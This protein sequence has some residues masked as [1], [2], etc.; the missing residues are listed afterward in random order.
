MADPTRF[1]MTLRGFADLPPRQMIATLATLALVIGLLVAALMWARTPTYSV[2]FS[3]L[4]DRDGGAIITELQQ[5]NIPYRYT[6]GGGAILVPAD[7]VHD[8]RL[9]LA[10]QGLP[11]GGAV[12]FEVMDSQKLGVSQFLEQLNYQRAL[13]GELVRSIQTLAAVRAARVHLAIPKSSGFLR[14]EQ[15][16][17]ASVLL[18]LYGGR[19]LEAQQVAG[20]AHLVA[21]SVPRLAAGAVSVI[22]QDGNLLSSGNDP[23]R[24]AGLDPGQ[25]KYVHEL[26]RAYVQRIE[27][28]LTPIAGSGN[29]R[30][31]VAADVDF[32]HNEQTAETYRPNQGENAP[33]VRSQQ[34]SET[35]S[36]EPGPSGVPGALTNQP[37]VPATAPITTPPVAG[38]P[39]AGAG[40]PAGNTE[41]AQ[42]SN[43]RRD[44]TVNYELDKTV[45]HTRLA[46]GTVKRL[47]VAVVV[48]H[49][50][51]TGA[52][53][54]PRVEPLGE[55]QLKQIQDLVREAV[56]YNAER[57]DTISVANSPFNVQAPQTIPDPPLW[58]QP[59]VIELAKEAGRVLLFGALV[60]WVF[61]AIARPMMRGLAERAAAFEEAASAEASA[62]L[63]ALPASG[64]TEYEQKMLGA[65][66]LAKHDPKLVAGVIKGWVGA[67]ER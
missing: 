14:D 63:A 10:S 50:R 66:E 45:R 33:S 17:S 25:L 32:S 16:P 61:F 39:R 15:K 5:Q 18:S 3:N 48:D 43:A 44:A 13:E 7:Q 46:V 35:L 30:A 49:R 38:T 27:T 29:F 52:D 62:T 40:A 31:Q 36:R 65:R 47:S 2:L 55:A 6:E 20:I 22:D 12:G 42:A 34:T 51:L 53:G 57:G 11:K 21:A 56:G 26:E 4:S 28:I 37:P 60:A 58:K 23:L 8:A 59:P 67:G 54:K 19:T 24:T 1:P 41:D 64:P 9:R